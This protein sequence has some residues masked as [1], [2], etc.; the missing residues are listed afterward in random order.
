M[1]KI[2]STLAGVVLLSS[3]QTALAGESYRG[4]FKD[5]ASSTPVPVT[6]NLSA[7][8]S[9]LLAGN[10][11]F[12]GKW[13]CGFDLEFIEAQELRK[14]YALRRAGAGRCEVLTQGSLVS[15]IEGDNLQVEL[16][17]HKDESLYTVGLVR[18]GK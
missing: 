4:T 10:I 1:K 3:L 16:L 6:V 5:K 9:P 14:F 2:I 15:R 11:R 13:A 8:N 18:Q 7:A 17:N 12:D